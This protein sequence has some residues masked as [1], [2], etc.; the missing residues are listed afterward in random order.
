ML[1]VVILSVATPLKY[2]S[3]EVLVVLKVFLVSEKVRQRLQLLPGAARS[4]SLFCIDLCDLLTKK[5]KK[6]KRY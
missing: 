1:L 5:R 3:D 2:T 6:E 4:L